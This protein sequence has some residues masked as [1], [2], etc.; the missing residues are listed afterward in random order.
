MVYYVLGGLV[1]V[2]LV[3]C[4]DGDGGCVYGIFGGISLVV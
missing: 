4:V 1:D 3:S 2:F